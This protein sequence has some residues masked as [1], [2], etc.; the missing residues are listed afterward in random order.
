MKNDATFAYRRSAGHSAT[1]VKRIVILYEQLIKDLSRAVAAMEK[2]DIQGRSHEVDHALVVLARLQGTLNEAEGGEVS[3]N[4][5]H[6]YHLLRSSLLTAQIRHIPE[7]LNKQIRNLVLLREAW[8]EVDRVETERTEKDGAEGNG[9]R[10]NLPLTAGA[11]RPQPGNAP[12]A[13][14][15][16]RPS[17]Q[18]SG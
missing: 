5:D 13:T 3:R 10:E 18:W 15:E 4:L 8:V 17:A 12:A 1:P 2:N 16:P 6:F 14:D 11:Q 7:M 9:T